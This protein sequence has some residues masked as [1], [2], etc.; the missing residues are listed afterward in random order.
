[1]H[2]LKAT[3]ACIILLLLSGNVLSQGSNNG[4]LIV[5][6]Y[7]KRSK[8]RIRSYSHLTYRGE[9]SS[10]KA[11]SIGNGYTRYCGMAHV[12]YDL[13]CWAADHKDIHVKNFTIGD[14]TL[15]F[16]LYL[17]RKREYSFKQFIGRINFHQGW[18]GMGEISIGVANYDEE[19]HRH[20]PDMNFLQSIEGGCQFNFNKNHF[21]IGPSLTYN[22]TASILHCGGSL[23][24]YTD[25][26]KRTLFLNPHLGFS[27]NTYF[28]FYFGYN[29]P[30]MKNEMKSTVNRFTF[31]VS[32]PLFNRDSY[33][34][35]SDR[36][37]RYNTKKKKLVRD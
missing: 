8:Q 17:P 26:D 4:C 34:F 18:R 1:M 7:D 16:D 23:I 21:I 25:F 22:C 11:D 29:I 20:I 35:S 31:T 13:F 32:V 19:N 10:L 24:Y 37:Y 3:L 36:N 15:V 2:N 12:N 5:N 14:Q 9:T 6:L 33:L 27:W 30:L 28:D